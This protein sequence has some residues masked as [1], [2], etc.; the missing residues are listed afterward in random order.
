[1]PEDVLQE[2]AVR[3]EGLREEQL[4]PRLPKAESPLVKEQKPVVRRWWRDFGT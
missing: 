3:P 1:M 4:R 2:R